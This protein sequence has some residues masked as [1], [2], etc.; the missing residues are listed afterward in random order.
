[1]Q[2]KL[3]LVFLSGLLNTARVWEPQTQ[4]LG[5]FYDVSVG[6]L[7]VAETMQGLAISVLQAAPARFSLAA[8]SMGGYVAFEILRQSPDRVDRLALVD[9][10]PRPDAPEQ[11]ARRKDLVALAQA[12][13]IGAVLPQVLPGFLSPTGA[14][15][16]ELVEIVTQM[17]TAVGVDAFIRQQAAIQGRPDSR[18]GLAA[19]QCPTVVIFGAEDALTGGDI[20]QEMADGIPGAVLAEIP[21]AGHLS[22]LENPKAVTTALAE[23]L[24]Y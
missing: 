21:D 9:T 19:I 14:C 2:E 23:W 17:A 12:E 16:P 22:P 4:D 24:A 7:T 20:A 15:N 3:P 10:T 1:M 8:L 13:G 5:S 6:D 18:Q 11:S